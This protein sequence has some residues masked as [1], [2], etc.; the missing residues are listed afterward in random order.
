MKLYAFAIA[1][2]LLA[3]CTQENE[4]RKLLEAHGY[5]NIVMRGYTPFGCSED[6]TYHDSFTAINSNGIY[7]SGVVCGGFFFKGNTIRFK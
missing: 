1:M 3:G 5:K 6:D 4:A 7:V 2:L